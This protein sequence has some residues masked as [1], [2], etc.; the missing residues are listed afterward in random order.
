MPK[1]KRAESTRINN[2]GGFIKKKPKIC[3]D[4]DKENV[5][6]PK[7]LILNESAQ[8]V[9]ETSQKSRSPPGT[10][11]WTWVLRLSRFLRLALQ[12]PFI[13]TLNP[14]LKELTLMAREMGT[15]EMPA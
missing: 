5:S 6:L 3:T 10:N 2:L 13:T 14:Y 7:R 8:H 12:T 15:R 11:S 1:R 9:Q 4:E